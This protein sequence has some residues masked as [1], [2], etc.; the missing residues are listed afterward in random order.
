[1]SAGECFRGT[2][3]TVSHLLSLY[4]LHA[5]SEGLK[6]LH[7]VPTMLSPTPV[8]AADRWV[9]CFVGTI[10][11]SASV[12]KRWNCWTLRQLDCASVGG[13]WRSF[14]HSLRPNSYGGAQ[15]CLLSPLLSPRGPN[16]APVTSPRRS[17][18]VRAP[19]LT[20][21]QLGVTLVE[22]CVTAGRLTLPASESIQPL[23]IS[24][25]LE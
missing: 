13:C 5:C 8:L 22:G 20:T 21:L 9:R 17:S 3:T 25:E 24:E 10:L 2:S 15:R 23:Q 18:G 1:M 11:A 16:D 12:G 14:W 7:A 4:A 6:R 19:I